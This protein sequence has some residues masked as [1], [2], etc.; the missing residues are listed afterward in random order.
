MIPLRPRHSAPSNVCNCRNYISLLYTLHSLV[1]TPFLPPK[2][3]CLPTKSKQPSPLLARKKI[4]Y[5][6][7]SNK[8]FCLKIFSFYLPFARSAE[9]TLSSRKHVF[10]SNTVTRNQKEK[11]SAAT[12]QV[13]YEKIKKFVWVFQQII[14]LSYTLFQL[15]NG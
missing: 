10:L 3:P 13:I 15:I 2:Q 14:N 12:H 5:P 11:S 8:S 9:A 7:A 4:Q 1:E 6:A